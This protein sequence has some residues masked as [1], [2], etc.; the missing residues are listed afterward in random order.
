L[1]GVKT[2][3]SQLALN[4]ITAICHNIP[5]PGMSCRGLPSKKNTPRQNDLT[6]K[7]WEYQMLFDMD[8]EH[9]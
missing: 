9:T 5:H 3:T 7:Y 6:D 8:M 1:G 2:Q 4:K